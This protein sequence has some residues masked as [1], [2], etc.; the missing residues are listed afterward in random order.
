MQIKAVTQTVYYSANGQTQ[1]LVEEQ[2]GQFY[3]PL[4]H[5]TLPT[6]VE[7]GLAIAQALKVPAATDTNPNP[8]PAN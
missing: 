3:V 5:V 8:N 6:L 4:G 1:L 2:P 7:L